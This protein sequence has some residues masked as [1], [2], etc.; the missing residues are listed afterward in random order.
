[1]ILVLSASVGRRFAL[2]GPADPPD[3]ITPTPLP[4]RE[5]HHTFKWTRPLNH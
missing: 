1:M 2:G 5:L 3:L 4:I